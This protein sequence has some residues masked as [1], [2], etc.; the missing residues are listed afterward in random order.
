M[1]DCDSISRPKRRP[2]ARPSS[3][4]LKVVTS[5]R[6]KL[7][8]GQ[9]VGRLLVLGNAFYVRTTGDTSRQW[10]VCECECGNVVAVRVCCII[11]GETSSCGCL[12]RELAVAAATTH[13]QA[14]T[15]LFNIWGKMR[16]RCGNSRRREYQWYGA[17]GI[18]VCSQWL[19]NFAAFRD[20][21]LQNG[22]EESLTIERKD[23]NK[24]YEPDNC[25]WIPLS[26]QSKN[27]RT[28]RIIEAFGEAKR[29]PQW[30]DDPRCVVNGHAL[31]TRIDT[32]GWDAERAITEPVAKLAELRKVQCQCGCGTMIDSRDGRGRERRF[33]FGHQRL[34]RT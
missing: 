23:N 27:R 10:V 24:G 30:V 20:W 16:A 2:F 14:D 1:S 32:Y 22:Y 6:A 17:R 26:E 19:D 21:A 3:C 18:K 31:R 15:R 7:L 13:G 28:C 4:G 29:V 34:K 5:E 33:V 12:H 8:V 25:E 11:R 9:K